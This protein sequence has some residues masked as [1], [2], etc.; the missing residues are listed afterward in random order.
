MQSVNEHEEWR[1]VSG[2][3]A[4]QASSHGR[5]RKNEKVLKGSVRRKY[6]S[7]E[8]HSDGKPSRQFLVHRLVA[9][10]FIPNPE[11]KPEVNHKNCDRH[12]NRVRN[13]EWVTGK[14]NEAHRFAVGNVTRGEQ[15]AN[16]KLRRADVEEIRIRRMDGESGNSLAAEYGV[17]RDVIY[18]V[19]LGKQWK[20]VPMPAPRDLE[21]AIR[22]LEGK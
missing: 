5:I 14:E 22:V 18:K 13:L 4:Y 12:D 7:I 2:W 8:L 11:N 17:S 9:M 15:N 6:V 19:A 21:S 16:A 10:A 1:D 20:H 3:P